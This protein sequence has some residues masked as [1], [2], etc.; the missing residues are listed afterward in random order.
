[1]HVLAHLQ[2]TIT[3]ISIIAFHMKY[4]LKQS[5]FRTKKRALQPLWVS[6]G[7]NDGLQSRKVFEVKEVNKKNNNKAGKITPN[8]Q[9]TCTGMD[10]SH[11]PS[12]LNLLLLIAMTHACFQQSFYYE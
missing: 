1:M 3:N 7:K 9:T 6:V 2:H 5:K 8:L 12:S 4:K 11:T 10:G